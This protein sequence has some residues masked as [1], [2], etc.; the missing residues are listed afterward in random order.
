[1]NTTPD[2][3]SSAFQ[4]LTAL[5]IVLG[6]LLVVFYLMKRFLKRGAGDSKGQLIR[7]IASQYIGFKK[8]IALVE[9]PGTILVIGVSNDRIS[10]LSKIEDSACLASI[11][12]EASGMPLSFADNLQRLTAKFKSA[13]GGE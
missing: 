4:M 11:R 9:V 5:G 1:M 7:V 3:V 6:G 8:N 2:V 13:K 12:Q 10:L